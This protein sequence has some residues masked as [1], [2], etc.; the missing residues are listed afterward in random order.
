MG[1]EKIETRGADRDKEII[2]KLTSLNAKIKDLD[3]LNAKVDN[4]QTDITVIK[5]EVST[6]S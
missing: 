6:K 1:V 4:M 3:V 2:E 5:D